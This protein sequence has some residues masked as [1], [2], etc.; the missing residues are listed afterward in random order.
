MD[1]SI[2][3][4]GH[5]VA[6]ARIHRLAAALVDLDL[7]VE[8]LGL[9]R[10]SDGPPGVPTS[11]RPRPGFVGR[12][13]YALT[14]ARRA[15]GRVLIALD[16][17]SHLACMAVGRLRRRAVVA[18]VH[19]DYAALLA[20]RAWA[21]GLAG[22]VASVLAGTSSRIARHSDLVIVADDHVPP[23]TAAHR[24]VLKN[25]PYLSMLPEGNDPEVP[26]RALYVG[27]VR[28]SRGLWSMIAA[29]EAAPGWHLDIVGPVSPSERDRL[30]EYALSGAAADR[31]VVHGR[32]PPRLAWSHAQRAT[33][34]LVLLDDTPAFNAAL[35]SKLYEYAA[36]GLPVIVTDLP[37]QRAFVESH[38]L[39]EVVPPGKESAAAAAAVLR[40]WQASPDRLQAHRDAAARWGEDAVDWRAQYVRAAEA[41]RDLR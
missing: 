29:I 33:C 27:D 5:D 8:V 22:K 38:G 17:D 25:L 19:E 14:V 24:I 34:G 30:D 39:G 40:T 15:R 6:D 7:S 31:V 1:V 20:D 4:S 18:D 26:P 36:C 11:A 16:P 37:R 3:S 23:A 21:H 13:F 35:P 10:P 28:A 41:I 2:V 32:Q 9:G 12:A